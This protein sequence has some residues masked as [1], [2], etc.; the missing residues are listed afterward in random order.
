MEKEEYRTMFEEEDSFWW[1]IGLRDLF[2]S[3]LGKL[4]FHEN[5][6]LRLLDCG[7][8]TG[9][10]LER[11]RQYEAT[12]MDIS[13]EAIKFCNMRGLKKIVKASITD[14]PFQNNSF[15]IITSMDVLYHN[16]VV[17]DLKALKEFY[18]IL[19][20]GGFLFLNLPAYD[21]LKSTH[22][23]VVHTRQRYTLMDV[24]EKVKKAGFKIEMISYR[25][26]FL[27]LPALV[28][29]LIKK[30]FKQQNKGG[31]DLKATPGILNKLFTFIL[32]VEN[33][34]I[35]SGLKF[36]FGLSIVCVARK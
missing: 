19:D 35:L 8:G 5:S 23:E 22:D 11:C 15:D 17:S 6:N 21:F 28:V 20:E 2:F 30:I 26:V 10:L 7:C 18:D 31:S 4:I 36:P 29:R 27:F 16:R 9:G 25:N 32:S 12:G 34:L 33:K 14:I 1:Y 24:R 3:C 13:K